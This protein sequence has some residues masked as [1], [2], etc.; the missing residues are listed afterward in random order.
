MR[1]TNANQIIGSVPVIDP[2]RGRTILEPERDE[3][4]YWVG[5]PTV[6]AEPER[7]RFL[8]TYRQRRPRG[9]EQDRGWRV[10]VAE[11]RDGVHFA[12]LWAV[13]KEELQTASMERAS[14]LPDGNGGYYLYLS[15]VDPGDRRWRIDLLEAPSPDAFAVDKR[16]PVL[17]ASS[18]G[19]EGVK[20]PYAVR[21]GTGVYLFASFAASRPFTPAERDAAHASADIYATGLTVCPAGLAVSGDGRSFHWRGQV[22]GVGQEWDRYESRLTTIMRTDG[23][24]LGLYDGSAKVEENY[25]EKTGLAV[26]A[27]LQHWTRLT[28]TGPWLSAPHGTGCLRYAEVVPVGGEWFVYY[29]MA[30]PHGSHE[31]RLSRVPRQ[32]PG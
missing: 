11:S 19:T 25:E 16:S 10:A 4:G 29:E 8:L 27:D 9:T 3:I 24:Y 17:T 30:R 6:L 28:T 2:G 5:S 7:D 15:Y 26:S 21:V 23:V 32:R 12:D 31:L 22:L 13:E 18:T 20:D 1:P 14:L